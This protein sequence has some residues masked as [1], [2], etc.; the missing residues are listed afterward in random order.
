MNITVFEEIKL[1]D[2]SQAEYWMARDLC[3]V[4][5]YSEYRHFL[6]VITK[7]KESAKNSGQVVHDHFEDI[8]EMVVLG[9]GAQRE[10]DDVKLSRY[11]CYL[12]IQN[13]DPTKEVVALG[14]T[15]FAIQTKRQ[16]DSDTLVED[17]KRV[18]LRDEI[19]VHNASLASSAKKA[20]V[21]NFGTFQNAG[22]KGLYKMTAQQIHKKKQLKKSQ[23]ILDH[24]GSEEL[25]ANLFRATQADAKLKREGIQGEAEANLA[26]YEVGQKVRQTIDQLGGTMP[27]NLPVA[28]GI[29]KAKTRIKKQN[30]EE[31]LGE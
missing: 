22:Y 18:V 13:S 21:S 14:Q 23:G 2:Y 19:S 5:G 6:P 10:I 4:L 8:L 12:I 15:Y 26:H 27:E 3:K 17:G 11:A 31:S 28:D 7:A 1:V 16:E 24:M 30:Q 20:G 9:S 29:N 25:A